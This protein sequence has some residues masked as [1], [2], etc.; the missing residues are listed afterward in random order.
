MCHVWELKMMACGHTE[1]DLDFLNCENYWE[2]FP[3]C[4]VHFHDNREI[5]PYTPG[6]GVCQ[7]CVG[8]Q[9]NAGFQAIAEQWLRATGNSSDDGASLAF[10]AARSYLLSY[11]HVNWQDIQIIQGR[12]VLQYMYDGSVIDIDDAL[13]GR[14]YD[15]PRDT[16]EPTDMEDGG[17]DGDQDGGQDGGQALMEAP[18]NFTDDQTSVVNDFIPGSTMDYDMDYD[19]DMLDGSE[20]L[21]DFDS[22]ARMAMEDDD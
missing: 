5:R 4:T 10:R 18:I 14:G 3:S 11:E 21:S 7:G 1:Q 15:I 12:L 6:D 13:R 8:R 20:P 19:M 2:I 17:Q 9:E 16:I 22:W